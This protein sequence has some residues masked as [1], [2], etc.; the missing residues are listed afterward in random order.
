MSQSQAYE[1]DT[2]G[3]RPRGHGPPKSE[4]WEKGGGDRVLQDSNHELHH[5][6]CQGNKAR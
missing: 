2:G 1:S 5:P 6:S 3:L 4:A